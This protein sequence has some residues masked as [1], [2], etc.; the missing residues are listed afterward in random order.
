MP[1]VRQSQNSGRKPP[2]ASAFGGTVQTYFL[3]GNGD[4][5]SLQFMVD[6]K[7]IFHEIIEE[8]VQVEPKKVQL[9]ARVKLEKPALEN[10]DATDLTIH[11]T[12]KNKSISVRDSQRTLFS[13]CWIKC[14]RVRSFLVP[15]EVRG[16]SKTSMVFTLN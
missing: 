6:R 2:Q 5:D 3:E 7:E 15:T 10:E 1:P 12:S 11:V 13:R 9:S 4:H 16:C 14:Y 8:V